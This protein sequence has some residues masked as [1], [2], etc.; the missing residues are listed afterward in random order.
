[1]KDRPAPDVFASA[2]AVLRAKHA[3][4]PEVALVL[5]SGL[6]TFADTLTDTQSTPYTAL[7]G[8]SAATVEGHAGNMVLGAVG[9]RRVVAMQGRVHLYEGHDAA[10]VVFGVRLML[11]LGARVLIVSN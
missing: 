3:Q 10:T 6:G 9:K 4:P 11:L 8:M 1:M 2:L 7:S 5:G